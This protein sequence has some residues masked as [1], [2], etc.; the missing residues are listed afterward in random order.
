MVVAD[1]P[2]QPASFYVPFIINLVGK[3][4][5]KYTPGYP[6]VLAA[7][8]LLGQPWL[9]NALAAAATVAGVYLLGRDLFDRDTGL[10][11]AALGAVSPMFVVLSGTLLPHTTTLAALTLFAW[12][13]VRARRPGEP[14]RAAFAAAG[15]AE[16]QNPPGYGATGEPGGC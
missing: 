13:F 15:P 7:G 9:V 10:L 8:V 3:R 2:A 5:G 6:L 1:V 14:R 4:F 16:S 12:A 11:A